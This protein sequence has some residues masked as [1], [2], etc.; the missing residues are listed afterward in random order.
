MTYVLREARSAARGVGTPHLTFLKRPLRGN[1]CLTRLTCLTTSLG[2]LRPMLEMPPPPWAPFMAGGDTLG[3]AP[4]FPS[5]VTI[6]PASASD[7]RGIARVHVRTW[8]AAYR[9]QLP[10]ELLEGL[11]VDR[12]ARFWD[13]VFAQ[14]KASGTEVVFVAEDPEP[15][16]VGFASA[17]PSPGEEGE[18]EGE[19]QTLYVLPAFQRRGLGRRL[20]LTICE[21]LWALGRGSLIAPVLA[22]HQQARGFYEAL[23]GRLVGEKRETWGGEE[24]R[25]VAYGWRSLPKERG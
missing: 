3:V 13:R 5:P 25:E 8:Q 10:D 18:F 19:L 15:R 6:R 23:G 11:S 21:A 16:L 17:G 22:S 7:A 12:R 1:G 24:V 9:R 20:F 14:G 4:G 2:A